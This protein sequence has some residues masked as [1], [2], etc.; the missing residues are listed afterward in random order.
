M[1][2]S[3][4]WLFAHPTPALASDFPS[5][6][7][8]CVLD[9]APP[10]TDRDGVEDLVELGHP[11][12]NGDTDG[13]GCP[14]PNDPDDDG[15]GL[16]TFDEDLDGDGNWQNDTERIVDDG[17][18]PAYLDRFDPLDDDADGYLDL[19]WGGDDCAD[20]YSGI[21]PGAEERWYDGRDGDC[22]GGSDFDQDGDGYDA[23][24]GATPGDDCDDLD[25]RTHPGAE[26]DPG[27]VDRDCDDFG[28]PHRA[29]VPNGG[30]SCGAAPPS[31]GVAPL[32][33]LAALAAHRRRAASRPGRRP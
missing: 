5:D 30:C 23:E 18:P 22:D 19:A 31:V 20:G 27:P 32:L 12:P 28:D 3:M 7:S 14:D 9:G 17:H 24:R 11:D 4:W 13:D 6:T 33:G 16:P 2:Q 1:F 10:D 26:E 25:P 21:H 15:D 8:G 29:L